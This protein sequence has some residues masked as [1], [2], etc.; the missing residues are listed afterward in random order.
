MG[1]FVDDDR[2][3]RLRRGEPFALEVEYTMLAPVDLFDAAFY[4]ED[5]RGV[6]VFDEALH[7]TV[8]GTAALGAAGRHRLTLEVDAPLAARE[9]AL[10][11]WMR[12][13]GETYIE[14]P[15]LRFEIEP[16]L[17]DRG[18]DLRKARILHGT[19]TWRTEHLDG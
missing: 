3:E 9:Y 18:S 16:A 8:S 11:L 10:S 12:G 7:E 2:L 14:E 1:Q 17:E 5:N 6:R 19:G 4:I 13:D 15:I